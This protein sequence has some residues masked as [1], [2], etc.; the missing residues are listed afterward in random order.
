MSRLVS[1]SMIAMARLTA[2]RDPI[3][4]TDNRFEVSLVIEI[5]LDITYNLDSGK[6]KTDQD[7]YLLG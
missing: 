1:R 3:T 2:Q 6:Q 5:V 7:M 4:L